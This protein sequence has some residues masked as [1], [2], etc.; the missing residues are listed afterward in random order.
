MLTQPGILWPFQNIF[1][2]WSFRLS[3]KNFDVPEPYFLIHYQ[4][5]PA[6]LLV[7]RFK[8]AE[9][10]D[11]RNLGR[12]NELDFPLSDIS[13]FASN[14]FFL[15]LNRNPNSTAPM[16]SLGYKNSSNLQL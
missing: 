14:G 16:R 10:F 4:G 13:T 9:P 3:K 7:I 11:F 2:L 15:P 6:G 8:R 5:P 12:E 1:K